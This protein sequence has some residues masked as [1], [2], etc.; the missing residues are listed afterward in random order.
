MVTSEQDEL[1]YCW[2]N[3]QVLTTYICFYVK[4]KFVS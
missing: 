4:C 1:A 3:N 2:K